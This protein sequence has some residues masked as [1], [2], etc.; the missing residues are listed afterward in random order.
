MT[1]E[2]NTELQKIIQEKLLIDLPHFS[3]MTL[4]VQLQ[5]KRNVL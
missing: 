2:R 4:S 5:P 3:I 1:V